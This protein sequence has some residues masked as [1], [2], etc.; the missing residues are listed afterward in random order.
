MLTRFE[1]IVIL[2]NQVEDRRVI[3]LAQV[4]EAI[5][6]AWAD[7]LGEDAATWGVAALGAD[8]DADFVAANPS[9]RGH[10]AEEILVAEGASAEVAAAARE[11]L[12]PDPERM[13]RLAAALAA[14]DILAAAD[15]PRRA[16]LARRLADPAAILDDVAARLAA[17]LARIGLAPARAFALI[18]ELVGR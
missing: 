9:R 5:L 17:A 12:G 4:R 7:D 16:E 10:V 18:P 14:G 6:V 3:H 2:R 1:T 11:R 15:G 8:I 13:S